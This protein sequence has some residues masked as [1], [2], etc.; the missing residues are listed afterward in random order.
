MTD[1]DYCKKLTLDSLRHSCDGL[2]SDYIDIYD[3]YHNN[4]NVDRDIC[5]LHDLVDAIKPIN[6]VLYVYNRDKHIDPGYAL[7][8][9][10]YGRSIFDMIIK[11]Y[12]D[13]LKEGNKNEN[14]Q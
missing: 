1:Y 14:T 2:I 7:E 5:F 9:L 11:Y 4:P 10:R 8:K 6:T 12:E 3:E 13:K